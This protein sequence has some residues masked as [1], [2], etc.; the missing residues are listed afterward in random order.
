M[1]GHGRFRLRKREFA[2]QVQSVSNLK[3]LTRPRRLQTPA[4]PP[5]RA[6]MLERV[7]RRSPCRVTLTLLAR[8]FG[9]GVGPWP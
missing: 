7:T 4:R 9:P 6:A 8:T 2:Q 3:L 5:I 1:F